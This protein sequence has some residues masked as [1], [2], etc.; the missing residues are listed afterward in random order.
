MEQWTDSHS[1]HSEHRGIG[2]REITLHARARPRSSRARSGP[3]LY[4][5]A[6]V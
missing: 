5:L 2:A 6:R 4:F 1:G 3:A